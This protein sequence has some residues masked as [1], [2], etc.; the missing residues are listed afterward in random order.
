MTKKKRKINSHLKERRLP[1][2]PSDSSIDVFGL[3]SFWFY[4]Y[5]NH[6]SSFR[7]RQIDHDGFNSV[8]APLSL[9]NI[10]V[11]SCSSE[12]ELEFQEETLA[13]SNMG[14]ILNSR[15]K[16]SNFQSPAQTVAKAGNT[17]DP[18][19]TL[20]QH[21]RGS[22]LARQPSN[23]TELDGPLLLKSVALSSIGQPSSKRPIEPGVSSKPH[24]RIERFVCH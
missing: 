23:R 11:E 1:V 17:S 24:R 2:A 7:I 20:S 14:E 19:W 22:I 15:L 18:A 6:C 13:D 16:N 4:F 5:R 21:N 12:E 3:F 9:D 10:E 8:V